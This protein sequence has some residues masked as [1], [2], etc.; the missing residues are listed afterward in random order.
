MTLHMGRSMHIMMS[1]GPGIDRA[2]DRD[3]ASHLVA[4]ALGISS[5]NVQPEQA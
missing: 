5:W 1:D 2:E 4:T 3:L